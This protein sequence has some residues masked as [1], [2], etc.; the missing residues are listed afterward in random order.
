L[1][2][3][4]GI[5][6]ANALLSVP[7]LSSVLGYVE[8]DGLA[9]FFGFSFLFVA[10][11]PL[12]WF[13]TF[14]R[15]TKRTERETPM[16]AANNL[17][18]LVKNLKNAAPPPS[19]P[20]FQDPRTWKDKLMNAS[21]QGEKNLGAFFQVCF[22]GIKKIFTKKKQINLSLDDR[23]PQYTSTQTVRQSSPRP[24]PTKRPPLKLIKSKTPPLNLVA[25][26]PK[27]R[28]TA[29]ATSQTKLLAQQ[30]DAALKDF[31]VEGEISAMHSGPVV[32]LFEFLPA[33]GVKS[34]RLIGLANDIARSMS[35]MSARIANIP[36]QNA[37]GIEI[38][39]Q[40]REDVHFAHLLDDS[41][42]KKSD[43]HLP[44]ILGTSISGAPVIADLTTMPHLLVAGTT[45]SGKSVAINAMI[46]SLLY[47]LRADECAL[48]MIDPKML[49]LSV[50]QDI[51]HLLTPVVTDPKKAVAALKWVVREMEERYKKMSA[52][53]VRNIG[54]YNKKATSSGE[55]KIP[56]IVVIIDEMADLMMVAGK[57]I[58]AAVQ[59]LAQMARAAGIHLIAA[60]QRPSVDVIT[61]TI[62]ANFPTRMSFQVSSKIDSRTILGEGGAEQLLGKGDMLWMQAG[63]KLQRVHGP[64]VTDDHVEK[65]ADFLRQN[66]PPPAYQEEVI[67]AQEETER[68]GGLNGDSGGGGG[69]DDEALYQ[70]AVALVYESKR[71]STSFLQRKLSIGY[72]RAAK[73]MERMEDNHI[74]STPAANGKRTVL[75]REDYAQDAS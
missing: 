27:P 14:S 39:N 17:S 50:Y 20:R 59:R 32:S 45:G 16:V 31:K 30:L 53:N 23:P 25:A 21:K 46:L 61:G 5:A 11:L 9:I 60:T 22:G 7:E 66:N 52:L 43:A 10:S 74:I 4:F 55:Q 2:G 68:G 51:P 15:Q 34:S 58:E 19:N 26:P 47:R 70:Q 48:I 36:G 33:A 54:N 13:R 71:A 75:T 62:K 28:K 18:P 72:N 3:S 56:F 38:P 41:L 37:I 57:E 65:V 40:K 44:L 73:M 6:L 49:E 24:E 29:A 12:Q 69:S 42:F 35:A 8:S 1:K 64:F 67:A 63:G